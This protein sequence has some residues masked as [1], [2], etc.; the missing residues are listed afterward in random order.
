MPASPL[1]TKVVPSRRAAQSASRTIALQL[2]TSD[3]DEDDSPRPRSGRT[4]TTGKRGRPKATKPKVAKQMSSLTSS[5]V[6]KQPRASGNGKKR[7][8][9]PSGSTSSLTDLSSGED[10]PERDSE[11]IF[12]RGLRGSG[13]AS[14]SKPRK[15]AL[16]RQTSHSSIFRQLFGEDEA[17]SLSSLDTYVWVLVDTRGR[18]FQPDSPE[19]Q[20]VDGIWWPARITSKSGSPP[21]LVLSLLGSLIPGQT[22]SVTV[23]S[24]SNKNVLA[25]TNSFGSMRFEEPAHVDSELP[26]S[27]AGSPKKKQRRDRSVVEE[28]WRSAVAEM[29]KHKEDDDDGLPEP[30]L[31]FTAYSS[32]FDEALPSADCMQVVDPAEDFW[33]PEGPDDALDIPGEPVLASDHRQTYWPARLLEYLHPESSRQ[34]Q[35]RYRIEYLDGK[36]KVVSRSKFFVVNEEGFS[37][38]KLGQFESRVVDVSDDSDSENDLAVQAPSSSVRASSP[39]PKD[40]PPPPAEFI[41]LTVHEQFVYTKPVLQAILNGTYTPAKKA[42][43]AFIS[44]GKSRKSLND[45]ASL[46]GTMDPRHVK[47]LQ[48]HLIEWCLRDER[49]A[50]RLQDEAREASAPV[51]DDPPMMLEK[52]DPDLVQVP[53]SDDIS[54]SSDDAPKEDDGSIPQRAPSLAPTLNNPPSSPGQ[55]PPAS[56]VIEDNGEDQQADAVQVS[57]GPSVPP[58]PAD[59]PVDPTVSAGSASS[60]VEPTKGAESN[61]TLSRQRGCEAYETLSR[62]EKLDYCINVLLPEAIVQILLWRSGD[63][64]S[65]QLLTDDEED[66]LHHLGETKRSERDWVFDVMRLR[67]VEERLAKKGKKG[68]DGSS[69]KA[70]ASGT[71]SRPGAGRRAGP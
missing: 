18:V 71:R 25:M 68:D 9:T 40:S 48:K 39:L 16:P 52:V 33:I 55:E 45:T 36:K 4:S 64:K 22:T 54:P 51:L 12:L 37:T 47:Q 30:G 19:S 70:T 17:W 29:L 62:I 46:R 63:R 58:P 53:P 42:H 7:Q 27:V 31:A 65:V 34:K 20:N 8:L 5:K 41:D 44:G 28:R 13:H 1:N 56:F 6:L 49:W 24:P 35:G 3:E 43:D 2:D 32:M 26:D 57:I 69:S 38:C 23:T 11:P 61:S 67:A 66:E 14:P 10:S 50:I 21:K 59:I 60:T 15:L